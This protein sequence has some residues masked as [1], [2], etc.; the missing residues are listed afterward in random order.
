MKTDAYMVR[1]ERLELINA[2]DAQLQ[3][4][5][6]VSECMREHQILFPER[7]HEQQAKA[8]GNLHLGGINGAPADGV[9]ASVFR[10]AISGR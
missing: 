10:F 6:Y 4:A 8:C 1:T 2:G 7:S 9:S 5:K 3:A